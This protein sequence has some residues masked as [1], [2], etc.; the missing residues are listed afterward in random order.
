MY[1]SVAGDMG[2]RA[3]AKA[4][5]IGAVFSASESDDKAIEWGSEDMIL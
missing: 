2:M 1:L 5:M 3:G 4:D